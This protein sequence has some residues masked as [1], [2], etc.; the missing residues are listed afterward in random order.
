MSHLQR[1]EWNYR[2]NISKAVIIDRSAQGKPNDE[3]FYVY[4]GDGMRVRKITQRVVD[5][6]AGTV[7]RT[8]KIY[9]DGCEIKRVTRGGA[10]IL[11]RST[12]TIS[13][14]DNT[15]ARLHSW[16]KDTHARETSDTTKK[17][18]HYQLANHL[19]SASLELDEQGDVI[20]YEEYFPYGGT[21]FIA[22]RNKR[23]I[24]LKEYRYSGKERDDITGLY[25]F[26]YR[27]YA[28]WIGGWLSPDPLG[29]EDSENLYLYVQN[30]PINVVDP[31][32][33]QSTATYIPGTSNDRLTPQS[34]F[35][36]RVEFARRHGYRLVDPNPNAERWV[37]TPENGHW[38]I[39]PEGRLINL[40]Q[41]PRWQEWRDAGLSEEYADSM[42]EFF[43]T[44]DEPQ[45]P[46]PQVPQA[47]LPSS[48]ARRRRSPPA[49]SRTAPVSPNTAEPTPDVVAP[50]ADREKT[51]PPVDPE[52]ESPDVEPPKTEETAPVSIVEPIRVAVQEGARPTAGSVSQVARQ[53]V[54]VPRRFTPGEPLRGPYN[55]WSNE[56]AL[57][58]PLRNQPGG[59]LLD[60]ARR[61]GYIME[62]TGLEDVAEATA[63]R[64]GYSPGT[65]P[66]MGPYDARYH[67]DLDW[68]SPRFNQNHFDGIWHPTS[69]ALASRAGISMTPVTSNGLETWRNPPHPNPQGTVQMAREI[70][71]IQLAGGLMG[72]F[73]KISGVITLVVSSQIDNPYVSK[74]GIAS[75]VMEFAGG[76]AYMLGAADLGG[77]YFGGSGAT[78][79]MRFG[80]GAVRVGG[81]V[82]MIVLS[83]YSGVVHYQQG[84]YGVVVGDAAGTGLGYM[85]LTQS[86]S[87]PLVAITTT[88]MLANYGGD[89][90]ESQVTPEY[91]RAAGITAGTATGLGIGAVVGGGLVAFG[92][93]SNPVG[94]G[95]LAVGGIAG[96]IGAYW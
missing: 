51:P 78:S 57:G 35:S 86:G 88:A 12:S 85:T 84:E 5:V 56:R 32:G 19:G 54:G 31:N 23:D 79:L 74:I 2:N 48:P 87:G 21:S 72:Q 24:E 28:H 34:T 38:E 76:S 26:G 41:D 36:D 7:E 40:R 53:R 14:G 8:E 49:P 22:G 91:G 80:S 69:D 90:V 18:I 6:A 58:G 10:E 93:V 42:V 82:G 68:K 73:A 11:K 50:D 44:L 89:Y 64:L 67:P 46:A 13:D 27:Y 65:D 63:R 30:N 92:L 43:Q 60:A 75:G 39:S 66:V 9:L 33:L 37:G 1:L 96:F 83:G 77:G 61:P 20:T 4:G 16:E 17:K 70:P 47:P 71:R 3:E 45:A 59:G 29:P 62:D 94:W 52:I 55:L 15:I 25:Y 95:I 81:G